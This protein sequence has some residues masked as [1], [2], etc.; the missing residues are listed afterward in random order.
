MELVFHFLMIR[1]FIVNSDL[2]FTVLEFVLLAL[3]ECRFELVP[4]VDNIADLFL[5]APN[6][7]SVNYKINEYVSDNFTPVED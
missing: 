2:L 4:S 7:Y 3:L 5:F 1:F 6:Y